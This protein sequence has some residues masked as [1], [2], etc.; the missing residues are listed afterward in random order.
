MNQKNFEKVINISLLK[1]I[2]N[3]SYQKDQDKKEFEKAIL[4]VRRRKSQ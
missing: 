3:N 4:K 1:K 2:V